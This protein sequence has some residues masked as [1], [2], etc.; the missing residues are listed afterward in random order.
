MK[1]NTALAASAGMVIVAALGSGGIYVASQQLT[2]GPA[3]SPTEQVS[4]EYL[5]ANGNL[6]PI[7]VANAETTAEQ[8][9]SAAETTEAVASDAG[10]AAETYE[11]EAGYGET[12][13]E[14]EHEED[15]DSD[16]EGEEHDDY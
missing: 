2:S 13:E 10:A 1:N 12:Y 15:D 6:V 11:G 14:D 8:P 7:D 16:E 5:D 9:A 4:I 3:A